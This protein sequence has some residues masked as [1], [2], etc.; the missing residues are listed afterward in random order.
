MMYARWLVGGA[1][2]APAA[3]ADGVRLA[4]ELLAAA[5]GGGGTNTRGGAV[6]SSEAGVAVDAPCW[7]AGLLVLSMRTARAAERAAALSPN[8]W[9]RL[10]RALEIE[11]ELERCDG[12]SGA[13]AAE[14]AAAAAVK[15]RAFA[16]LGE[17]YDARCFFLAPS[18]RS[19]LFHA[20]DARCDAMLDAGLLQEVHAK[21]SPL[22][23]LLLLL[24]CEISSSVV[25]PFR[26]D[27][28]LCARVAPLSRGFPTPSLS[29]LLSVSRDDRSARW[30]PRV[31]CR[32]TRP[33]RAPSATGKL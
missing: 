15:R 16:P 23:L 24:L 1:P 8:D 12:L 33:P 18:D 29:I 17:T 11:L 13:E 28:P 22:L 30:W 25:E 2:D 20:I 32:A 31:A 4:A 26:A 9:Y 14:A 5:R 10:S 7:E 27:V 21:A 6:E 3:S 19:E